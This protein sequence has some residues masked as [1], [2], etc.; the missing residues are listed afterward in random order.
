MMQISEKARAWVMGPAKRDIYITLF[1]FGFG[2]ILALSRFGGP[3]NIIECQ[4]EIAAKA[5]TEAG[6]EIAFEACEAKFP[7]RPVAQTLST[8]ELKSEISRRGYAIYNPGPDRIISKTTFDHMRQEGEELA[9]IKASGVCN[10]APF[11][12]P[13]TGV[14]APDSPPKP[15][16]SKLMT[17][18]EFLGKPFQPAGR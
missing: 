16:Q 17:D 4:L 7:P 9:R 18:E 14:V 2:G 1:A 10:D 8:D 11:I 13:N 6:A 15:A 3:R 5:S 12:P